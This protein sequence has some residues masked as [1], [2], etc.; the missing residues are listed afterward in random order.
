[1]HRLFCISIVVEVFELDDSGRT[2]IY[3]HLR[4]Y[5]SGSIRTFYCGRRRPW[6]DVI[7][8]NVDTLQLIQRRVLNRAN[9]S[10][11]YQVTNEEDT[12]YFRSKSSRM[13]HK[14]ATAVRV[15]TIYYFVY[16]GLAHMNNHGR[17]GIVVDWGSIIVHTGIKYAY[18]D[19]YISIFDGP[20]EMHMIYGRD[21]FSYDAVN[22][23]R[24]AAITQFFSSDIL[25]DLYDINF[26]NNS[27]KANVFEIMY[28]KRNM[29]TYDIHLDTTTHINSDYTLYHVAYK[30]IANETHYPNIT[31]KIRKFGGF[32]EG[33]CSLGGYV[34]KR[35]EYSSV[36]KPWT[37]GPFCT[38]SAPNAPLLTDI[39]QQY[40]ISGKLNM[41][42]CI[43]LLFY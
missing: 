1:M 36:F 8:S 29:G 10:L 37:H 6:K 20:E 28:F 41:M 42:L 25:L 18:I 4:L 21:I 31:F 32:N 2:C 24:L 16:Q 15:E 35:F 11:A 23:K 33:G 13:Y 7:E 26:Q 12:F 39:G 5:Q 38:D 34:I 27:L 43:R 40:I 22:K 14:M 19:G 30:I 9:I 3:S 17:W